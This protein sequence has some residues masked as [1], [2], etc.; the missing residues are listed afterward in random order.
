MA[1]IC[2]ATLVAFFLLALFQTGD[3][4]L[5]TGKVTVNGLS[6]GYIEQGTGPTVVLV[7]GSVSDYR[8]WSLQMAPLAEHYHVFAYSRRHHW[9]NL[10]PGKD[11]DASVERQAEDLAAIIKSKELAPVHIVGHSF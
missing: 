11:A 7:H 2:S 8:E 6:F 3:S 4:S 1:R 5:Q 10:P 9:P